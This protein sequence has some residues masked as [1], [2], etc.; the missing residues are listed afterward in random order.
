MKESRSASQ[1]LFGF[2]PEQTVD[3]RGG[4]WKVKD[5]RHPKVCSEIDSAALRREI[6][7]QATHWR[8]AGMDAGYVETSRYPLV[9]K[10]T[11]RLK[12]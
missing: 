2:L 7:R 1:I 4:V 10:R 6:I 9:S 11:Q 5:W 12:P 3:L 8:L